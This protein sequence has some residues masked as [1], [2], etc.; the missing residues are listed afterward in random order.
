MLQDDESCGGFTDA[1]MSALGTLGKR[2]LSRCFRQ[3][4]GSVQALCFT[5]PRSEEQKQ[6][7]S[8]VPLPDKSFALP[9]N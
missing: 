3:F 7:K 5:S 8:F 1:Q 6:F 9:T 2:H 4:E